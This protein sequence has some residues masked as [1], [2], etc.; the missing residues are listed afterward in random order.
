MPSLLTNHAYTQR[1]VL[2]NAVRA[3]V[4]CRSGRDQG[5]PIEWVEQRCPR[6][7]LAATRNTCSLCC[8]RTTWR[9]RCFLEPLLQLT[10]FKT[11]SV[12]ETTSLPSCSWKAGK[13]GAQSSCASHAVDVP[14]KGAM[15]GVRLP[16]QKLVPRT[17]CSLPRH[18]L[19][20]RLLD[21]RSPESRSHLCVR[22]AAYLAASE[23]LDANLSSSKKILS[24]LRSASLS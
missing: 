1:K 20:S 6:I 14:K 21:E 12:R 19:V 11:I 10:A 7:G 16:L 8:T 5:G 17:C 18:W 22:Q 24:W 4:L 13:H 23:I 9:R 2:V 15:P 3:C